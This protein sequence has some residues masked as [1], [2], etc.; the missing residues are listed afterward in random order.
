MFCEVKEPRIVVL[1]SRLFWFELLSISSAGTERLYAAYRD[2]TS[3]ATLQIYS[4][5]SAHFDVLTESEDDGVDEVDLLEKGL[6]RGV[7]IL[8]LLHGEDEG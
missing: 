1:K 6:P 3:E 8:E 2:K 4:G 5:M 7:D